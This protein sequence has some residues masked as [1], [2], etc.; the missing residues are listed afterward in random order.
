MV[1]STILPAD[2]FTRTWS[3]ILYL[4]M[5]AALYTPYVGKAFESRI[6]PYL[7]AGGNSHQRAMHK[8]AAIQNRTNPEIQPEQSLPEKESLWK[9]FSWKE[10]LSLGLGFFVEAWALL[11]G[12]SVLFV[13]AFVLFSLA[14]YLYVQEHHSDWERKKKLKVVTFGCSMSLLITLAFP[15]VFNFWKEKRER[16][17]VGTSAIIKTPRVIEAIPIPRDHFDH[18]LSEWRIRNKPEDMELRDLFLVDFKSQDQ[19]AF[20]AIDV[21]FNSGPSVSVDYEI[22]YSLPNRSKFISFYVHRQDSS[23]KE[24]CAYLVKNAQ[25]VLENAPQ[26]LIEEKVPGDSS[27]IST[28]ETVFS[29]RVY[30]YHETYLPVEAI[31]EINAY[32]KAQNISDILRSIDYLDGKKRDAMLLKER[33]EK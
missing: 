23:T 4:C 8:A 15:T 33:R 31:A 16:R 5:L 2:S 25:W 10:V 22:V 24:I 6:M 12:L 21:P 20:G 9:R 26:L 30:I 29:R 19:S 27:T 17:D 7:W 13:A 14:P 3:P 28:K 11:Y 1:A 32:S 18:S